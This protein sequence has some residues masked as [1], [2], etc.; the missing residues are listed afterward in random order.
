[1]LLYDD[2]VGHEAEAPGLRR[3]GRFLLAPDLPA[4]PT[5][6]HRL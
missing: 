4:S 1:M 6:A 2:G 5:M 3:L